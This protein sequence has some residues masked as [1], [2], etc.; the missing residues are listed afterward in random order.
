MFQLS[1][2]DQAIY[3]AQ[4]QQLQMHQMGGHPPPM[5]GGMPGQGLKGSGKPVGKSSAPAPAPV[6][7]TW[8]IPGLSEALDECLAPWLPMEIQWTPEE[9]K[10]KISTKI[11]K[12]AGKFAKEDRVAGRATTTQAQSLVEEFVESTMSAVSGGFYERDYFPKIDFSAPMLAAVLFA[13]K[14]GK[15]FLRTLMP[16]VPLYVQEGLDK[17][18]EEE[19]IQKVMWEV[20]E[21]CAVKD[22]Y[23]K[24]CNKALISSFDDAFMKSPY[25]T[26][27]ALGETAGMC[28]LKDYVRGWMTEFVGKGWEVI[29]NGST[30]ATRDEQILFVTVLFQH[31]T[32]PNQHC[33][34]REVVAQLDGLPDAPW[35]YIAET[36][37]IIFKENEN[38]AKRRKGDGKGKW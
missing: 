18:H 3:N 10:K 15:V 11:T 29:V 24:K 28:M 25:G 34:P 36:A 26:N 38:P 32:D 21:L 35:S 1:P 7:D 37:E 17:W 20:L 30:A 9:V 33:L 6:V 14:D 12:A 27:T 4:M 31:L 19:R 5:I 16:M 2:H 22:E 23:R 13:F 8:T